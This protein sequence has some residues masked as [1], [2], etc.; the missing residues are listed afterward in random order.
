MT[1]RYLQDAH[2]LKW[3]E[4]SEWTCFVKR[5]EENRGYFNKALAEKPLFSVLYGMYT[6]TLN[7][8]KV[9]LKASAQAKQTD[10]VNKTSLESTAQDDDFREVTR[11]KR[12]PTSAGV[13]MPSKAVLTRKY[14]APLRT[15]DNGTET[16]GAENAQPEHQVGR[17]HSEV[18]LSAVCKSRGHNWND[19]DMIEP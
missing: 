17:H 13:K 9:V 2:R 3:G 4:S 16:T 10:A 15:A 1:F 11:R 19:S 7:E 6:V 5:A 8:L 14:F 18:P 12:V